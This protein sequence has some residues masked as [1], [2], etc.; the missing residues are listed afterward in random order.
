[1][2]TTAHL[3]VRFS[4]E[5]SPAALDGDE[6]QTPWD[7]ADPATWPVLAERSQQ[8]AQALQTALPGLKP[9]LLDSRALPVL[10]DNATPLDAAVQRAKRLCFL[11]G[12][13]AQ[14]ELHLELWDRHV[15][16]YAGVLHPDDAAARAALLTDLAALLD[17]V[18]IATGLPVQLPHHPNTANAEQAA[19]VLLQQQQAALLRVAKAHRR[20]G[21]RRAWGPAS[22]LLLS[23][24][25]ALAVFWLARQALL[26]GALAASVQPD[27]VATF[28]A[29]RT[30]APAPMSSLTQ[31]YH[32]SG[33]IVETGQPAELSVTREVFIRAAPGARYTVVATTD[34]DSPYL[35]RGSFEALPPYARLWGAPV[36]A[37]VGLVLIPLALW[38]WWVLLPWWRAPDQ[39]RNA[40]WQG[41]SNKVLGLSPLLAL[42]LLVW[43]WRRFF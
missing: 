29:Q 3:F 20:A 41:M 24:L 2:L 11:E 21:R 36:S 30:V 15:E 19:Q 33:T 12:P 26:D 22:A 27:R 6:A 10:V 32:L 8:R 31:Q 25:A 37:T 1:M 14:G 34:P 23:A 38:L 42:L 17:R 16:L 35:L 39:G 5:P 28:V 7:D 18:T 4:A 40:M 43:V 13:W 9:L